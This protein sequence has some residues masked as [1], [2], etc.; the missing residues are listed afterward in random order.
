MTQD[1]NV[2]NPQGAVLASALLNRL[3]ALAD[4]L[5]KLVLKQSDIEGNRSDIYGDDRLVPI[6]DLHQS[7]QD[8]LR[9]MVSDLGCRGSHDLVAARR[10]GRL[11]AEQGAPLAT[12][13]SSLPVGSRF[14]WDA[15][16]GGAPDRDHI[17]CRTG[18]PRI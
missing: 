11:R 4:E 10:T 16:R 3:P 13:Q 15:R 7:L 9:F 8:I 6:D 14:M 17:R 12:V 1:A 18:G 2:A 5:L